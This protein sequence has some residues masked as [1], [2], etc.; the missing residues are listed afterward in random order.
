MTAPSPPPL[1]PFKPGATAFDFLGHDISTFVTLS[2]PV[3]QSAVDASSPTPLGKP[4][5]IYYDVF[6]KYLNRAARAER[7]VHVVCSEDLVTCQLPLASSS[8]SSSV[9][10]SD[11]ECQAR[12]ASFS[13]PSG[14]SN[15]L[16][17]GD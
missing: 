4:F 5:Y 9:C 10:L 12:Q 3:G 8:S 7:Q 17:T 1:P 6:D 14:S 16:F 15:S 13:S 11:L 2:T